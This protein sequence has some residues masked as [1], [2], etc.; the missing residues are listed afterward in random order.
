[1]KT[2]QL[3]V[4]PEK[5]INNLRFSFTQST[6]VL[7]ELMQNA[8]RAGARF[9]SFEYSEDARTLTVFD[10]GCGIACLKTLLTVAESGWDVEVIEREHPFGLGFLSAIFACDAISVD[11]KGGRFSVDTAE[12][13]AFQPIVIESADWQ[14]ITRLTLT[15]FKPEADQIESQLRRLARG[16][17]IEVRFNG[18]SLDRPRS[19]NSTLPFIE[20]ELGD[21]YL[22]GLSQGEDWLR[23]SE[24]FHLYLQGLPVYHSHHERDP[25]HVIH[26]DSSR[27]FARLPDRD[28]L[29]DEAQVIAEV[30][31]VLQ[32]E[33]RQRLEAIKT[34]LSTEAFVLGY[35][36][37]KT[38]RCL[39][40]L[41]DVP[42]LPKQ[43]LAIIQDYPIKEGCSSVNLAVV[44]QPV[45]RSDVEN[46]LVKVADLDD[47]D[48]VGALRWMFAWR[49]DYR[50]FRPG[51]DAG[52]W[53]CSYLV[54]LNGPEVT[55]DI[56]NESHRAYFAG[57][58]VSGQ[59]VFCEQ[60]RLTLNGE[61]VDI[62]NDAVYDEDQDRFIVPSRET[63][64][65]VV[66]QASSYYDEWDTF[67][68]SA[69]EADEWDFH[70]FVVA[71][72]TDK[73]ADALQRLL[74]KFGSCPALFSRTFQIVLGNS[75]DVVTV[76]EM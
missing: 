37:L 71:N 1:M 49:R 6:T 52:H 10:D 15:Q 8:R 56:V 21:L 73:P 38:Y 72:T 19:V 43:V 45:S 58:W 76:A 5:L 4:N 70:N 41:N 29:I 53:L 24:Y 51:L 46:G 57:Q 18:A 32:R 30:K 20:T 48:E 13:L 60:Y 27:F 39:D 69:K 42:L 75:G 74:P 65:L 35:D 40:L 64:G 54:D 14:G 66:C 22:Y 61:S 68:E 11:S 17:P 3:S 26:L 50:I 47:L 25:G 62:D 34:E 23:Q 63:F 67:M 44:S 36:T 9:I 28:K 55:L 33:A 2:T 16:F 12:L 59:A 31:N 7:G